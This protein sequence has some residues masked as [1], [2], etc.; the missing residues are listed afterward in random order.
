MTKDYYRILGVLDDAEDI[1]I[2]AS[3]R[4]LAQKYHPDKWPGSHAESS[5]KMSRLG[6]RHRNAGLLWKHEGERLNPVFA[7]DGN[8]NTYYSK[9]VRNARSQARESAIRKMQMTRLYEFR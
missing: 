9:T 8:C 4:A 5:K 3:Y 6:I 2:R 1:V 7:R